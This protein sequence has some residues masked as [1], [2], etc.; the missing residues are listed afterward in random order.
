[1]ERQFFPTNPR[2]MP[3]PLRCGST[4]WK[5]GPFDIDPAK[6]DVYFEINGDAI[7]QV[8][9]KDESLAIDGDTLVMKHWGAD[10]PMH[11]E[12]E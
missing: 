9:F 7:T 3:S 1:M 12:R 5:P 6:K 10:H 2:R 8:L 4:R 11:Y